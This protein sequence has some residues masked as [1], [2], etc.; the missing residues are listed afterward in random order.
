MS[1]EP[2]VPMVKER[3]FIALSGN[4]GTGKT[5]VLYP[6]AAKLGLVPYE[7]HVNDNPF[8]VE[9]LRTGGMSK[10]AESQ[11][12]FL[13]AA[14]NRHRDIGAGGGIQERTIYEH[15][16]VFVEFY[17]DRGSI[18]TDEYL[19]LQGYFLDMVKEVRPPDLLVNLT[20][21]PSDLL[22]RIRR[23]ARQGE[24]Q[25][26]ESYL[27]ALDEKYSD[28]LAQWGMGPVV[29]SES[30]GDEEASVRLVV[31]EL[32]SKIMPILNDLSYEIN[33]RPSYRTIPAMRA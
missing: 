8:L 13:Q 7:E 2:P 28:F 12:Y 32:A 20:A 22:D 25:L 19:R 1:T 30:Y 10:T 21:A 18:S 9:A 26:T 24:D 5:A 11:A 4:D 3:P 31:D 6:L 14:F 33:L 23:R 27:C 16:H 17:R 15:F 29:V